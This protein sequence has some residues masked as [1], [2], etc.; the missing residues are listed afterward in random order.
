MKVYDTIVIRESGTKS[1]DNI[2]DEYVRCSKPTFEQAI[3]PTKPISDI[4]L[5]AGAEGPGLDLIA[6]GVMDDIKRKRGRQNLPGI[7]ASASHLQL[8]LTLSEVDLTTGAPSY[9]QTV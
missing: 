2:L 5:P 3:L 9:Y 6:H 4:I 8:P 1:L 7:L